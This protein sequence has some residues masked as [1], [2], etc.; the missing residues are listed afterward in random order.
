MDFLEPQ[1]NIFLFSVDISSCE[2]HAFW[3]N[4][5]YFIITAVVVTVLILVT[6]Q[7]I[8]NPTIVIANSVVYH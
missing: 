2:G 7:Y 1:V 8:G 6:L 4:I 5:V 3:M